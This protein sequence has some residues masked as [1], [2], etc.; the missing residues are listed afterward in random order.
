MVEDQA[1]RKN[2]VA[3]LANLLK[4]FSTIADFSQLGS[5]EVQEAVQQKRAGK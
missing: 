1:V 3:L 2:R 4:E 5:E